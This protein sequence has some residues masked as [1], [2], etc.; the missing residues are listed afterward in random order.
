MEIRTELEK[1]KRYVRK[2]ED[3]GRNGVRSG[4]GEG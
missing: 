4:R 3:N 1:R 2:R